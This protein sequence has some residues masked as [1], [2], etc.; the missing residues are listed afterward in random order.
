M[1]ALFNSQ[2][3]FGLSWMMVSIFNLCKIRC[4]FFQNNCIL[5][6]KGVLGLQGFAHLALVLFFLSRFANGASYA[7]QW[8]NGKKNGTGTFSYP[9]GS[10]YEGN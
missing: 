4:F 1:F 2:S 3:A 9:D 8:G 7:G 10:R 5:F 6:Q